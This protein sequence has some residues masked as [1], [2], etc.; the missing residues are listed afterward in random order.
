MLTVGANSCRR[1][2]VG[3]AAIILV[4]GYIGQVFEE[5]LKNLCKEELTKDNVQKHLRCFEVDASASQ[6]PMGDSSA[7]PKKGVRIQPSIASMTF[8]QT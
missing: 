7:T 2:G 1:V 4:V 6:M 3:V 5:F 8:C